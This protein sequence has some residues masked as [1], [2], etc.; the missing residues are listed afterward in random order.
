VTFGMQPYKVL[1]GRKCQSPMYWDNVGR[2]QML[3]PKMIKVLT[4]YEG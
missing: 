3:G 1:Y 2:R 4:L